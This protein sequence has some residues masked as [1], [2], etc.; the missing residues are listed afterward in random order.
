MIVWNALYTHVWIHVVPD[1][2]AKSYL[3]DYHFH[4]YK[5]SPCRHCT[6][7]LKENQVWKRKETTDSR[8]EMKISIFSERWRYIFG[9]TL[10]RIYKIVNDLTDIPIYYKRI[11]VMKACTLYTRRNCR[12]E[13][14]WYVG[15]LRIYDTESH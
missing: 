7:C 8:W 2:L 13:N 15:K 5:A 3:A 4:E 9:E 1:V 6:V 11:C 12:K 10:G 14:L